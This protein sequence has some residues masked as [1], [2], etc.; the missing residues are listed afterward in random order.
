MK[1]LKRASVLL[2]LSSLFGLILVPVASGAAPG[3][4]GDM[5]IPSRGAGEFY[6]YAPSVIQQGDTQWVWT[7]Q[8][9]SSGVI[10]DDIRLDKVL[11][12]QVVESKIALTRSFGQWDSFHVC[13]P[14]VVRVDATHNG[15]QYK[16]ALFYLGNDMD[17][18]AHN[19]I[20]IA[21]AKE[22]NGPWIKNPEPV[23]KFE[24]T[25]SFHR[26]G[27]GQPSV[28]T[29]NPTDGTV[30]LFWV[31][32][33]TGRDGDTAVFRMELDVNEKTGIRKG[34][35]VKV[36]TDGLL[37]ADG[38]N[39][40]LNNADFSYDPPTDRFYVVRERHPYPSKIPSWIGSTL[41]L[42]SI[43]GKSIWAGG[44]QWVS[45][46]IIGPEMTGYPRNHNGGIVRT[47]YG[48]LPHSG[49]VGIIFATSCE[50]CVDWLWQYRLRYTEITVR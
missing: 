5:N 11:S 37:G 21:Y 50:G 35:K 27:A 42:V 43:D 38:S 36:T 9:S 28:T 23:V 22:L 2:C 48:T 30:L 10:I 1:F 44:G 46:G 29:I 3:Q 31:E 8:N 47:E 49:R 32:N 4:Y 17:A 26:W 15:E 13:D 34:T 25:A 6:A 14:S 24:Q 20:G 45:H 7:C 19:Q 39:D 41:E 12:G 18:S 33:Y 40:W 16:Y